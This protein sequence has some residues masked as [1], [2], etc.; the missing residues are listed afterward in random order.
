MPRAFSFALRFAVVAA[1]AAMIAVVAVAC[2][3]SDLAFE[4]T[5]DGGLPDGTEE[6]DAPPPD[7]PSCNA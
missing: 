6:G 3:R 7:A 1:L 4:A 5:G 2:G